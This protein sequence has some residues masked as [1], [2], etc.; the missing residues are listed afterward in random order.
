[1]NPTS[2]GDACNVKFFKSMMHWARHANASGRFML[3]FV[4]IGNLRPNS[5]C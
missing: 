5:C 3:V 4:N 2:L 1:M